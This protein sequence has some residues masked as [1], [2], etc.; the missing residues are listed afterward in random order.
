MN[1]SKGTI[2][3]VTTTT[4]SILCNIAN[5]VTNIEKRTTSKIMLLKKHTFDCTYIYEAYYLK[6]CSPI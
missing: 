5:E 6:A 3:C 2:Y 4:T 1:K